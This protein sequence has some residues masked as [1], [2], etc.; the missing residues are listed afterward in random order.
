ML[1]GLAIVNCSLLNVW[2]FSS[3]ISKCFEAFWKRFEGFRTNFKQ[4]LKHVF[5]YFSK[6][7][8]KTFSNQSQRN[9]QRQCQKTVQWNF[10]KQIQNVLNCFQ[11]KSKL[12]EKFPKSKLAKLAQACCINSPNES[13]NINTDKHA[14]TYLNSYELSTMVAFF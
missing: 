7:C 1:T 14:L 6:D 13:N 9:V 5:K 4:F 12:A 8:S 3:M 11:T 10:Q 2:N